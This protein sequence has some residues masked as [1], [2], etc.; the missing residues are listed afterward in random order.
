M[1]LEG[2][3]SGSPLSENAGMKNLY[4]LATALEA[5]NSVQTLL[6]AEGASASVGM[7]AAGATV[8]KSMLDLLHEALKAGADVEAGRRAS[9]SLQ[10]WERIVLEKEDTVLFLLHVRTNFL[11]AIPLS[12]LTEV[13]RSGF[14]R[15][16]EL[17]RLGLMRWQARLDAVN[18]SQLQAMAVWLEKSLAESSFLG[19][20][21]NST[22]VATTRRRDAAAGNGEQLGAYD[23]ALRQAFAH[24]S[25]VDGLT[26]SRVRGVGN[27]N[28]FLSERAML[29]DRFR[30]LASAIAR[31]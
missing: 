20:L 27:A 12:R 4:A 23:R 16:V 25:V 1:P 15:F 5:T 18:N 8:A 2:D 24:M 14:A 11:P 10:P 26:E 19:D 3:R 9:A 13:E 30:V 7:P 31:D 17:L 28:P 6:P 29:V 21:R 22:A